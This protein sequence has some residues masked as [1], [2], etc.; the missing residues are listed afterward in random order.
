MTDDQ[1][2][3]QETFLKLRNKLST[4]NM[5]LF[6]SEGRLHRY[7]EISEIMEEFYEIRYKFYQSRKV[8]L[9]SAIKRELE[10]MQNK[11]FFDGLFDDFALIF[12]G[13]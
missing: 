10:I 9:Q 1:S 4:N 12:D 5:V 13:F 7:T 2:K 6:N 3:V 8:Y 11:Y